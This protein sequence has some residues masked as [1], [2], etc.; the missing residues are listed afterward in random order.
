MVELNSLIVAVI[1]VLITGFIGYM[2]W[3]RQE[4]KKK[5]YLELDR[6]I[7]RILCPVFHAIRHIENEISAEEREK[8]LQGFFKKYSGEDSNIHQILDFYILE[9]Y[10]E[11]ED[12]FKVFLKKRSESCWE[13]FWHNFIQ[14]KIMIKNRY[15]EACGIQSSEHQWFMK[16]ERNS[17]FVKIF[18]EG[19]KVLY[20][21]I[22]GLLLLYG[23][24]IYFFIY[25]KLT[26]TI[27]IDFI[28]DY[29]DVIFIFM[30]LTIAAFGLLLMINQY[31]TVRASNN[32]KSKLNTILRNILPK[33]FKWW[34]GL[35]KTK[36]RQKLNYPEMYK[37]KY[38]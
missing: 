32:P 36:N 35:F 20:D 1:P 11:T 9:Y 22:K 17:V 38:L 13:E 28:D 30:L 4:K 24:L 8:S 26:G 25:F 5:F 23:W 21:M 29:I 31:E 12:K 33:Y 34:D 37:G 19:I 6:S 16:L 10:Y 27:N 2:S 14:L 7:E 15:F 18:K 3:I